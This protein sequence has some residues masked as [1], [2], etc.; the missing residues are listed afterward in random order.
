ME[1]LEVFKD[2][3]SLAEKYHDLLATDGSTRGFISHVRFLA[4]GTGISLTVL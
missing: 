4:C 3:L 1:P 2:R